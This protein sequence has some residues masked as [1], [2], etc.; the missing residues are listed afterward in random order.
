MSNQAYHPI[1]TGTDLTTA[2]GIVDRLLTYAGNRTTVEV[3][4]AVRTDSHT[5]I[6]LLDGPGRR[7]VELHA[8]RDVIDALSPYLPAHDHRRTADGLGVNDGE[9]KAWLSIGPSDTAAR[10]ALAKLPPVPTEVNLVDV[11]LALFDIRT[12]PN[13]EAAMVEWS[14]DRWPDVP[15]LELQA[16][17]KHAGIALSVN[18]CGLWEL[19]PAGVGWCL[20]VV[21]RDSDELRRHAAVAAAAV[22]CLVGGPPERY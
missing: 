6:G 13:A 12:I 16:D 8:T 18:S 4:L 3:E 10:T 20:Y 11:P 15:E 21:T 22:G 17:V 19:T 9:G 7:S 14:L 1:A 5:A 2:L